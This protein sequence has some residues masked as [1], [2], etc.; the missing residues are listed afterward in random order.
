M[1]NQQLCTLL[2]FRTHIKTKLHICYL[3]AGGLG[4]ANFYWWCFH[5]WDPQESR[6][7]NSIGLPV[8]FLSPLGYN[9]SSYSSIRV[10]KLHPLF[11][12]GCLHPVE[13]VLWVERLRGQPCYT[14]VCKHNR[15]SLIVS[16]IGVCPWDGSQDGPFFS[17]PF[18]QSML[19]SQYLKIL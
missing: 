10:P 6:I 17:L 3:C 12:C 7:D 5:F 9:P 2:L 14:S 13:S 18:P 4:P 1:E 11:G 15:V 19:Y 16:W 8:E